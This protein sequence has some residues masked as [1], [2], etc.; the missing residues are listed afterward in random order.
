[1]TKYSNGKEVVDTYRL[2]IGTIPKSFLKNIGIFWSGVGRIQYA[3]IKTW[4][5][6][7][8]VYYGDY[9]ILSKEGKISSLSC[10]KLKKKY[11]V[12]VPYNETK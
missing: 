12:N 2:G 3:K 10:S 7:K 8:K 1:M 5:G 6:S 9:L 4:R 11:P